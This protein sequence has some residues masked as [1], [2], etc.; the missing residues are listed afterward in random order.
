M[1]INGVR[2]NISG[3][4]PLDI[5]MK[6]L[7][8][9][10]YV[11]FI[12]IGFGFSSP[13]YANITLPKIDITTPE[14]AVTIEPFLLDTIKKW[15]HDEVTLRQTFA[16]HGTHTLSY[17][18]WIHHLQ[19]GIQKIL[20]QKGF[21][22][23]HVTI[24]T[25]SDRSELNI[26][27]NPGQRFSWQSWVWDVEH[28]SSDFPLQL[29][30]DHHIEGHEID[31]HSL[32]QKKEMRH[33]L[34]L[35]HGY[36]TATW[37]PLRITMNTEDHNA[38]GVWCVRPGYQALCG[39]TTFDGL[40]TIREESIRPRIPWT[41]GDVFQKK[42]A[43]KLKKDLLNTGLFSYVDVKPIPPE[44]S[45]H[46]SLPVPIHV[47]CRETKHRYIGGGVKY[48]RF[49]RLGYKVFW[50]HRNLRNRGEHLDI[51]YE[52]TAKEQVG[53]CV[54]KK[55]LW[56]NHT[57]KNLSIFLTGIDRTRPAYDE[58]GWDLG[59]NIEKPWVHQGFFRWG[60]KGS[61]HH[62]SDIAF[63]KRTFMIASFPLVWRYVW[64]PQTEEESPD[65]NLITHTCQ[66]RLT[67]LYVHEKRHHT[68]AASFQKPH[69]W[70]TDHDLFLQHML[71]LQKQ[72]HI[73]IWGQLST[74]MGSPSHRIPPHKRLYCGGWGSLR[75]YAF[76]KGGRFEGHRPQGGRSRIQGGIE[77]QHAFS[78][79]L[80]GVLFWEGA[81]LSSDPFH[82]V[83]TKA[84]FF[85]SIGCGVRYQTP[86]APLHFD[87]AV[88]GKKRKSI[89]RAF[90][91]YIGFGESL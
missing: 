8:F 29:E 39:E 79:E 59:S 58:E 10:F 78:S 1:M 43:E 47:T 57:P 71:P 52:R 22:Q 46:A 2:L 48:T 69:T 23:S 74:V 91:F 82:R 88:P 84:P 45:D 5:R 12:M 9:L 56:R 63:K 89:D 14:D 6:K 90:E 13:L 11:F 42:N 41:Q 85:H 35:D 51:S 70:L 50:G 44:T 64:R 83:I 20:E 76:Q 60:I 33:Q 80:K 15:I 72:L 26:V 66:Y 31:L 81:K 77:L 75:G 65:T 62:I 73:S 7:R 17:Q 54:L 86:W 49:D 3:L 27:L 87:I 55:T 32:Y 25:L 38:Q 67:P 61:L 37:S 28:P 19:K 16:P 21:L 24:Q 40:E 4:D 30:N 34:W 36:L 53:Q 18:R 68:K